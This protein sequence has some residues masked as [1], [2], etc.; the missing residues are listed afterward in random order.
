MYTTDIYLYLYIYMY[1]YIH[2]FMYMYIYIYNYIYTFIYI[3]F[4]LNL[5]TLKYELS[6]PFSEQP[7][8]FVPCNGFVHF[9]PLL[10]PPEE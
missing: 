1:I 10:K 6:A 3:Y 9:C 4:F 5:N 7:Y 2:I 8:L